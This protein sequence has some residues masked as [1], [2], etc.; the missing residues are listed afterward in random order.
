MAEPLF[1]IRCEQCHIENRVWERRDGQAPTCGKCGVRLPDP[2]IPATVRC[3]WCLQENT[4][5]AERRNVS[6][7]CGFCGRH[8]PVGVSTVKVQTVTQT[9]PLLQS[10]PNDGHRSSSAASPPAE[11]PPTPPETPDWAGFLGHLV[12]FL[13][14]LSLPDKTSYR[15]A[16]RKYQD[17]YRIWERKADDARQEEEARDEWFQLHQAVK[18]RDVDRMTGSEFEEF[19]SVLFR[20]MDYRVAL[21][22]RGPDQ[23][24]DLLVTT[25][26]GETIAVQA[27]RVSRPVGNAAVQELLGGMEF[28]RCS[29]GLVVTNRAF[30]EAAEQLAHRIARVELWER[31]TLGQLIS[32]HIPAEVPPFTWDAYWDLRN[33]LL[34]PNVRFLGNLRS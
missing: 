19:L 13:E 20:K 11:D 8:L 29:R 31:E 12:H 9:A 5:A 22:P 27:K 16:I 23:G 21:T 15:E 32:E 34:S 18:M 33:R 28:Y 3:P 6:P 26:E 1:V 30:T 17:D 24:A 25:S 14:H 2:D 4:I 7:H 10:L